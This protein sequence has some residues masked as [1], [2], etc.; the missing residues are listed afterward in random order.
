MKKLLLFISMPAILIMSCR[1]ELKTE[2]REEEFTEEQVAPFCGTVNV[3]DSS[4]LRTAAVQG[5]PAAA[6][7][8][9]LDFDGAFVTPGFPNPTGSR[10]S[11]IN[12]AANCPAAPLT[13]A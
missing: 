11:I 7:L 4:Q 10:S 1:K 6:I 12:H 2:Q 13:A 5:P 3:P 9:F 8:I